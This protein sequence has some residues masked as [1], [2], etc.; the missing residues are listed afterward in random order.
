MTEKTQLQDRVK[1][2]FRYVRQMVSLPNL[3]YKSYPAFLSLANV[4]ASSVKKGNSKQVWL[5]QLIKLDFL[6]KTSCIS[7]FSFLKEN[8]QEQ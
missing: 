1:W 7:F 5:G 8:I 6:T 4:L 2:D 3:R